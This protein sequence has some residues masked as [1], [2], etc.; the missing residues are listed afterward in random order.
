MSDFE[1][2]T[3]AKLAVIREAQAAQAGIA[4]DERLKQEQSEDVFVAQIEQAFHSDPRF[5]A[6]TGVLNDTR[7]REALDYMFRHFNRGESLDKPPHYH[8]PK[9]DLEFLRNIYKLSLITDNH[10]HHEK[11]G[12]FINDMPLRSALIPLM[13]SRPSQEVV[14]SHFMEG[15]A[16][17]DADFW[18]QAGYG[19]DP[20]G[21]GYNHSFY[22]RVR[23]DLSTG[24]LI[25]SSYTGREAAAEVYRQGFRS[26]RGSSVED[27]PL[28]KQ[29]IW[30]PIGNVDGILEHLSSGFAKE[31]A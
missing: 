8:P 27:T 24:I 30:K 12:E 19:D 1:R 11:S 22:L 9:L 16:G 10:K 28:Y 17:F 18:T 26:Y 15:A 3:A 29:L 23:S 20:G 7:I 21:S 25:A 13:R 31:I 5:T 14:I 2:M 6:I 4:K